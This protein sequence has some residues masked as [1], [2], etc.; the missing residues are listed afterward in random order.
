MEKNEMG[1]ACGPYGSGERVIGSGWGNRREG[2][3]EDLG[4]DEW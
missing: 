4:E 3:L 1:W 2:D